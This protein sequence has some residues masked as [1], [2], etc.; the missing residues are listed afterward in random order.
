M[1]RWA[2]PRMSNAPWPVTTTFV[3]P[4][5]SGPAEKSCGSPFLSIEGIAGKNGPSGAEM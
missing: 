3:A 2:E 1:P 4:R 5:S